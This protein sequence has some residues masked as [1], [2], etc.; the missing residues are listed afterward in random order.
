MLESLTDILK[1]R[2]SAQKPQ[3]KRGTEWTDLVQEF[4]KEINRERYGTKW[5]PVSFVS[6]QN[7]VSHLDLETLYWFK[8]VCTDAKKRNGSFSKCFFGALKVK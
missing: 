5:A 2:I 7:K 6:V 8:S 1:Q 4:Q 3:S